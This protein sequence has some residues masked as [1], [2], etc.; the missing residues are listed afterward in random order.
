MGIELIVNSKPTAVTKHLLKG[1][2]P[3]VVHLNLIFLWREIHAMSAHKIDPEACQQDC[4]PTYF[5]L[6]QLD[7]D[8]YYSNPS[9]WKLYVLC[10][11]LYVYTLVA[12][13]QT[14]QSINNRYLLK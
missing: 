7:L 14:K 3:I 4:Q 10:I 12:V 11:L 5:T 8:R 6:S 9:S 1:K 13:H 2:V